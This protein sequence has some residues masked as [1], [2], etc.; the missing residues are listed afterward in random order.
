MI[1][2]Y[3]CSICIFALLSVVLHGIQEVPVAPLTAVPACLMHDELIQTAH[4]GRQ[5]YTK[6]PVVTIY[7]SFAKRIQSRKTVPLTEQVNQFL[8][9][10][11]NQDAYRLAQRGLSAICCDTR[12]LSTYHS[13]KKS[14]GSWHKFRAIAEDLAIDYIIRNT[15]VQF[16]T[17]INN[18]GTLSYDD[19][20]IKFLALNQHLTL[21][22]A[23]ELLAALLLLHQPTNIEEQ[24]KTKHALIWSRH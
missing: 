24:S 9:H 18:K 19:D 16:P 6:H 23:Q 7:D 3:F 4:I 10:K 5:L 14:E 13:A 1:Y 17:T 12:F 2:K 22:H 15:P 20:P 21:N 11:D 8:M